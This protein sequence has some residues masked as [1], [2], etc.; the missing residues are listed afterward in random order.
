MIKINLAIAQFPETMAMDIEVSDF[1]V[2]DQGV[3]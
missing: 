3:E 1:L 2:L